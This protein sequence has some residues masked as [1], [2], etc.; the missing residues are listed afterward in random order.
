MAEGIFALEFPAPREGDVKVVY[1]IVFD[2][3]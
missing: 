3:G 1:R 2:S